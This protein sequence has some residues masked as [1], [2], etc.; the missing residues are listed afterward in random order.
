MSFTFSDAAGACLDV[1]T[2]VYNCSN[3]AAVAVTAAEERRAGD[4]IRPRQGT[5]PAHDQT[6]E[7][8]A[9]RAMP[10]AMIDEFKR[11]ERRRQ[12]GANST[13]GPLSQIAYDSIF[14]A[15]QNGKLK[16]GS[17]VRENELT[18]WLEMSRTPVRDALRR[19]EGEGLL[20]HESYRGVVISSLDRQMVSELYTAREWAEVSPPHWPRAM[21]PRWRSRRCGNSSST[22]EMPRTIRRWARATIVGY[23]SPSM[24]A[25][26]TGI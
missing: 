21:P 6:D 4:R 2:I 26:I 24:P 1:Y 8:H 9:A 11:P 7:G 16:P 10:A 15:I 18:E 22:K 23:I 19:L 25:R 17:R 12:P 5:G 14:E 3:P 20:R 13:Q